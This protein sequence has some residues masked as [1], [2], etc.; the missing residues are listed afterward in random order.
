MLRISKVLALSLFLHV[1]FQCV[2]GE[3]ARANP[4]A[5]NKGKNL[6]LQKFLKKCDTI[7]VEQN[8]KINEP[9]ITDEMFEIQRKKIHIPENVQQRNTE[10]KHLTKKKILKTQAK[11]TTLLQKK[12]TKRKN[13]ICMYQ[14]FF[15]YLSNGKQTKN[16]NKNHYNIININKQQTKKNPQNTIFRFVLTIF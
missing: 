11:Q 5:T 4:T 7:L 12:R 1:L 16:R 9:R 13:T 8:V 10:H 2:T 14:Q 15:V 6:V 3:S